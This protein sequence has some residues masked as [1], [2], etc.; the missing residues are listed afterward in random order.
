MC[1]FFNLKGVLVSDRSLVIVTLM[2]DEHQPSGL[3]PRYFMRHHARHHAL[4][5]TRNKNHTP[6]TQG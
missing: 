4:I 5:T 2:S 3:Q 1:F 6:V